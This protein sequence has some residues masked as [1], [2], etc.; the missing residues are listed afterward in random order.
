MNIKLN[1]Q[2]EGHNVI[3]TPYE[4]ETFGKATKAHDPVVFNGGDL[5]AFLE[6]RDGQKSV[7]AYG[8]LKLLQDRTSEA[9]D[10][11]AKLEGMRQ[12]YEIFKSGA[13]REYKE[14]TGAGAKVDTFFVAAIAEIKGVSLPTAQAALQ[15]L[16]K[17][18]R[19]QLR[20]LEPVKAAIARMRAES[21]SVSLDD[22]LA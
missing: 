13:W 2:L 3:V 14:S 16:D 20:A 9:V 7:L 1:Y 4:G 19:A 17:D 22:L 5:P 11:E 12:Y 15:K 8:L 10:P 21:D 6:A 18:A